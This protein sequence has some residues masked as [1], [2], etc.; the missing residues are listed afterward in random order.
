MD[1]LSQ[2]S[3]QRMLHGLC[4]MQAHDYKCAQNGCALY[5]IITRA[6]HN[7]NCHFR[8]QQLLRFLQLRYMCPNSSA[9]V[10]QVQQFCKYN[11]SSCSSTGLRANVV[12]STTAPCETAQADCMQV[13]TVAAASDG[14]GPLPASVASLLRM[15]RLAG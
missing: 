3:M 15:L 2:L 9:K 10:N 5:L 8:H 7:C 12:K 1:K 11:S 4:I 6:L 13:V 14:R